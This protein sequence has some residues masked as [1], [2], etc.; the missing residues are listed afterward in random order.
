MTLDWKYKHF[1]QWRIFPSARDEV[2]EAA[3]QYVSDHLGSQI[4]GTAEGFEATGS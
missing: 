1:Y 4:K 2:L 3:R